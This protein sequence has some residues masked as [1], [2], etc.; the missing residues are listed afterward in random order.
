MAE[1]VGGVADLETFANNDNRNKGDAM[2]WLKLPRTSHVVAASTIVAF[3]T[4]ILFALLMLR[5]F[6][7]SDVGEFSV[8]GQIATFWMTLAL[9][10]TQLTLLANI[11]LPA[12][13]AT[14][15][16]WLS[17]I[18]RGGVLLPVAIGILWLSKLPIWPTL[19]W[20]LLLAFF[21]MNWNLAKSFTLRVGSSLQ[22]ASAR[23]LP[24]LATVVTLLV[25]TWLNAQYDVTYPPLAFYALI[26]Y[27]TGSLWLLSAWTQKTHVSDSHTDADSTQA[28]LSDNRHTALKI[29]HSFSDVFL[30]TALVLIWQ[31]F[32]GS[33]ETG[34]MTTLLR[35]FNFLPVLVTMAWAQVVLAKPHQAKINPWW[36]GFAAFACIVI[37]S[38]CCLTAIYFEWLDARWRGVLAYLTPL[39][40]WQGF[41]C[42]AAAFSHRPFQTQA[43]ST[44]SWACMSLVALQTLVLIAPFGL[45]TPMDP[46][47]HMAAFA[48]I[49][50]VGLLGLTVWMARL[51]DK[52]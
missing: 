34:W 30:S 7:P 26:G 46:A 27:V 16:A 28:S 47:L 45:S 21:Q 10:Q 2:S 39:V 12:E 31:R 50:S 19:V 36:I 4:Q 35:V 41:A 8:I 3:G 15:E 43:A 33:V 17:S 22:Q 29:A 51:R 6:S 42:L 40:L 48:L 23:A 44:Y 52:T 1:A 13:Q 24:T 9:A 5:L 32:Y 37:L 49:S 38:L 20:V 18:K 25:C 11:Q 14:R